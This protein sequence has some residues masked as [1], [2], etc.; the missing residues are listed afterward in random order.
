MKKKHTHTHTHTHTHNKL[1]QIE[2]HLINSHKKISPTIQIV[3][4]ITYIH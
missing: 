1:M 4:Y 2:T 3:Y